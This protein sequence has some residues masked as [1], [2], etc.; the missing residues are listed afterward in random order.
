MGTQAQNA[1]VACARIA[2]QHP[3]LVDTSRSSNNGQEFLI[4]T[5]QSPILLCIDSNLDD[6]CKYTSG[7]NVCLDSEMEE[8]RDESDDEWSEVIV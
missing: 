7:V 6:N 4:V 2:K 5:P 3:E 1:A 8:D